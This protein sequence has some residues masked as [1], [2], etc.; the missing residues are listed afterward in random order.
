MRI[1]QIESNQITG[2]LIVSSSLTLSGSLNV[3]GSISGTA[4]FAV[5]AS[6]LSGSVPTIVRAFYTGSAVIN[7]ATATQIGGW[8]NVFTQNAAEWN[9]ATGQ[10][11][12]TKAGTYLVSCEIFYDSHAAPTINTEYNLSVNSTGQGGAT[13]YHFSQTTTSCYKPIPMV[14]TVV[15]LTAGQ[16]INV[17]TYQLSGA[18]RQLLVATNANLLSIVEIPAKIQ[19]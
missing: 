8:T 18:G 11:T 6:A 16:I 9:A 2:S 14:T 13:S 3:T 12:A 4:S 7:N 1:D 5:S 17:T 15:Q 19:R 10:F